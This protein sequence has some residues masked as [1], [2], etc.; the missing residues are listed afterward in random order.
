MGNL[1]FSGVPCPWGSLKILLKIP[2]GHD[3]SLKQKTLWAALPTYP[4]PL[5]APES[6]ETHPE[7]PD[8]FSDNFLGTKR[9]GYGYHT[10]GSPQG[11][12]MFKEFLLG[13]IT[14]F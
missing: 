3:V 9:L 6:G 11:P 4:P 12:Y 10:N 2:W 8:F 1:P 13:K 7:V 14:G 5:E